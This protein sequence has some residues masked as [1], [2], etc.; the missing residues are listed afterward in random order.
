MVENQ[1]KDDGLEAFLNELQD[2]KP[3]EQSDTV[4]TSQQ[5]NT[6][7]Q[8]L[9][10]QAIEAS[11]N[12]VNNYLSVEKVEPVDPYDISASNK[13]GYNKVFSKI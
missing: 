11:Q 4:A 13:M 12:F 5:K 6:L 2:V 7:A 1:I 9:K 10:R 3:I 8:Q